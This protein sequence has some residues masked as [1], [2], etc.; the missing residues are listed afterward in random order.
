MNGN[1]N[2]SN[3]YVDYNEKYFKELNDFSLS[4]LIDLQNDYLNDNKFLISIQNLNQLS[5]LS[6][7]LFLN[8]LNQADG[9]TINCRLDSLIRDNELNLINKEFLLSNFTLLLN[10]L[11]KFD[12]F[13]CLNH[14]IG[15]LPL[16]FVLNT[17]LVSLGDRRN[18]EHVNDYKNILSNLLLKPFV[19]PSLLN[20][21]LGDALV[22]NSNGDHSKVILNLSKLI[23]TPPKFLN[24]NDYISIIVPNL[25][26]TISNFNQS[27]NLFQLKVIS[28]SLNLLSKLDFNLVSE[29]LYDYVIKV[30]YPL[31][32]INGT[33]N[34]ITVSS[35]K[36][37]MSAL[38][39]ISNLT[40][41]SKSFNSN[42]TNKLIPILFNLGIHLNSNQS[43]D[44]AFKSLLDNIYS[45]WFTAIDSSL[46]VD[47]IWSTLNSGNGWNDN[48]FEW[49]STHPEGLSIIYNKDNKND[50]D[51]F[52]DKSDLSN[53]FNVSN[54]QSLIQ[55]KPDPNLLAT[56]VNNIDRKDII[57]PL[58]IKCLNQYK[59]L[60]EFSLN[61]EIDI[62]F[63]LKYL[64]FTTSLIEQMGD[65]LLENTNDILTFIYHSVQTPY[66][67]KVKNQNS[68]K[69]NNNN[70]NRG[71]QDLKIFEDIQ[72][73]NINEEEEEVEKENVDQV[74]LSTSISLLLAILEA[75]ESINVDN[76]PLLKLIDERL[77][78]LSKYFPAILPLSNE[79]RL[80][81]SARQ[82]QTNTSIDRNE[83]QSKAYLECLNL[84][85]DS[86]LP[87]RAHGLN[88]LR[89][90][91]ENSKS[92]SLISD[93]DE[94][95][96]NLNQSIID[97]ILNVFIES[98]K[99][100]DSFI[101]LNAV[102]GLSTMADIIGRDI[103]KVLSYHYSNTDDE[104]SEN[105]LDK[106]LKV[107]E[108]LIQVIQKCGDTLPS[109][110]NLI[111]PQLLS[112]MSNKNLPTILR[113]SSLTILS[114]AAS[115]S[116]MAI[117]PYLMIILEGVNDILTLES[118]NLNNV[119]Q[120]ST[121]NDLKDP[122]ETNSKLSQ[123]RKSSL[124]LIGMIFRSVHNNGHKLNIRIPKDKYDK[125]LDNVKYLSSFDIDD[126]VRSQ[127]NE[128][129][130]EFSLRL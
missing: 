10:F 29:L 79:S 49:S 19:I 38:S 4:S 126:L 3:E 53:L 103:L 99:S 121:L 86:I 77:E 59:G 58:F 114:I 127:A 128:I 69:I 34:E 66:E 84:V 123:L 102:K 91:I 112:L 120:S 9:R 119:K 31:P 80:I 35:P 37:I 44:P 71:K 109:Y 61:D 7:E 28:L 55:V 56:F 41:I 116:I 83:E 46:G 122:L 74:F 16:D 107:G 124:L 43:C 104:I 26:F 96:T 47:A 64:Q 22:D 125:I 63:L 82:A 81:I 129:L 106:R 40:H 48:K 18:I 73:L 51:V 52:N 101:Y 33:S 130:D 27:P 115:T 17:L 54:H 13:G 105:E 39:I 75:N 76:T 65:K 111:I 67:N 87:V 12:N 95:K 23:S 42:Y 8:E 90:L 60:Q 2:R 50:D 32:P 78:I 57:H 85:Q 88:E 108:A 15:V 93:E 62:K 11:L 89:K 21:T 14:L 113:S 70:N 5:V 45:S 1:K 6:R 118:I 24:S 72:N 92:K 97:G 98:I 100:D 68:S 94:A 36:S 25:L 20:L 110:S 30:F 117:E